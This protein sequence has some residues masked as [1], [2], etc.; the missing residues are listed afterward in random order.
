M[1]KVYEIA[2]LL[3]FYGQLLTPRQFEILDLQYNNDYSLGEIAEQLSISRQ[4]VF[5]N[6]KRAKAVL[7]ELEEKLGL[8]RKFSEQ[9][10]KAQ[11]LLK[12]IKSIETAALETEYRKQLKQLE[13]KVEDIINGI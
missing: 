8:V 2:L 10:N 12:Y 5:D 3:D 4:G 7:S 1:D 9:Q 11:E 13:E 6:A